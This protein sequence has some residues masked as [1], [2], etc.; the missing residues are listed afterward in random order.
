MPCGPVAARGRR[1]SIAKKSRKCS[2]KLG[3]NHV[4]GV[5]TFSMAQLAPE[6]V[7]FPFARRKMFAFGVIWLIW[8][9]TL[10]LAYSVAPF[11]LFFSIAVIFAGACVISTLVLY[12]LRHVVTK[13][14]VKALDYVTVLTFATALVA[15]LEIDTKAFR[16]R[17]EL[18]ES[19]INNSQQ[20]VQ[21]RLNSDVHLKRCGD[22]QIKLSPDDLSPDKV[23]DWFSS[24]RL[25][26]F[27]RAF[28]GL[29]GVELSQVPKISLER[30]MLFLTYGQ[31]L[32]PRDSSTR[33]LVRAFVRYN[34]LRTTIEQKNPIGIFIPPTIAFL[35]VG[36]GAAVR[37]SRTTLEVFEWHRP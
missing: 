20:D 31:Y 21:E 6:A 25:L 18:A 37:L 35:L 28:V 7:T 12:A 24:V 1:R 30:R 26:I 17:K 33:E 13:S 32:V 15:V 2:I 29:V 34:Y 3:P 5:R 8:G 36:F 11:S 22:F 14:M 10:F 23:K 19:Q 16:E 9:L 27:C 4:C